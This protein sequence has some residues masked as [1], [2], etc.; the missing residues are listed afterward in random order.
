MQ[1]SS[2]RILT[3]HVG[4]LPRPMPLDDALE[5]RAEE[6]ASYSTALTRAV[7]E[8][9]HEQAEV[10]RHVNRA[11]LLEERS[12]GKGRTAVVAFDQGSDALA[13]VI[14][15]GRIFE[16]STAG[17]SMYVD[18]AGRD[19][20]SM[21][22]DGQLG[23]RAIQSADRDNAIATNTDIAV[24]PGVPGSIHNAGVLNQD[25]KGL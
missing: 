3:T 12:E 11:Q 25:I 15:R 7:A 9:V 6:E 10:G 23:G 24:V 17:V 14:L 21:R 5:R 19:C 16:N 2:E 13:D 8:V 20:Q 22:V 4:S 1:H 18:E